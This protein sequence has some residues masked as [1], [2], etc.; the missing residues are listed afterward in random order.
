MQNIILHIVLI[1]AACAVVTTA[2]PMTPLTDVRVY[3]ILA[4]KVQMQRHIKCALHEGPCDS[5]GKRLRTLA[6]LVVR[7]SCPQCTAQEIQQ[8]R[9]TLAFIQRNYPLEWTRL[10]RHYG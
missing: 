3:E 4:D 8:I 6:P 10:V 1:A 2:A 9:R 7:G 5:L